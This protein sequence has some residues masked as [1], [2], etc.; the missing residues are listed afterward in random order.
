MR[1]QH[2][3]S[4][5]AAVRMRLGKIKRI[6]KKKHNVGKKRLIACQRKWKLITWITEI[7]SYWFVFQSWINVS[8]GMVQPFGQILGNV[9]YE[10][11]CHED[12]NK[13]TGK[14]LSDRSYKAP[15][16]WQRNESKSNQ[17]IKIVPSTTQYWGVIL[18]YAA[19]EHIVQLVLD[20]L[21]Y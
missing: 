9:Y 10:D 2:R 18:L 19:A 3:S 21:H 11:W 12:F 4:S 13:Q 8:E 7:K 16:L 14:T 6:N 17:N 20:F 1:T 5:L 15:G